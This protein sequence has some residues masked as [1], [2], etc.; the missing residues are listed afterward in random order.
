MLIFFLVCVLQIRIYL[1]KLSVCII[2]HWKWWKKKRAFRVACFK[3]HSV[4]PSVSFLLR[5]RCYFPLRILLS[6]CKLRVKRGFYEPLKLRVIMKISQLYTCCW[7]IWL[8]I[9]WTELYMTTDHNS[10]SL[11]NSNPAALG[12]WYILLCCKSFTTHFLHFLCFLF[13]NGK[14]SLEGE[15]SSLF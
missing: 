12:F 3:I 1:F 13:I 2:P 4:L 14:P 15:K 9:L 7:R 8:L 5:K 10:A 11:D 6:S